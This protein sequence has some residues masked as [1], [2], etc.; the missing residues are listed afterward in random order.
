VV[1]SVREGIG[2]E[3]PFCDSGQNTFILLYLVTWTVDSFWLHLS[4]VL[5]GSIHWIL[6]GTLAAISIAVGMYLAQG[7]HNVVFDKSP[8]DPRLIDWGVFG[9]VRHPM[10][11][12]VLLVLLGLFLWSL[13]LLSLSVWI[14]FFFFYDRMASYEEEDLLR[15]FGEGY[16]EYRRRVGK[17]IPVLSR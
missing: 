12:G 13:S 2:E 3:H 15:I 17:W 9:I 6:R 4:T 1:E 8:S 16:E 7:A 5:T 10:Y 14:C 11:L